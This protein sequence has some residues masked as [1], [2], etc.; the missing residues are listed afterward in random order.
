MFPFSLP[1]ASPVRC[2]P[3]TTRSPFSS[4]PKNLYPIPKAHTPSLADA[5]PGS[6]HAKEILGKYIPQFPLSLLPNNFNSLK[7]FGNKGKQQNNKTQPNPLHFIQHI[8][9]KTQQYNT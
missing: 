6:Q 1:R 3:D 7:E 2:S 4:I 8:I 9:A 5:G